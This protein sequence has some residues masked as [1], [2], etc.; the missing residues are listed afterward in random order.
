MENRAYNWANAY[1][2]YEQYRS[3]NSNAERDFLAWLFDNG[4]ICFDTIQDCFQEEM[5][6]NGYFVGWPT[7]P[8]F[9]LK[10]DS[11]APAVGECTYC[12]EAFE[13]ESR[14]KL[15]QGKHL[16][17]DLP[18]KGTDDFSECPVRVWIKNKRKVD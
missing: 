11:S 9:P 7:D 6:E 12:G 3:R 17:R 2:W 1:E 14:E 18:C 15:E 4:H 5:D 10:Q 13:E 16:I 8:D